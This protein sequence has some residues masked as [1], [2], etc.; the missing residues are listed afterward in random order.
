MG[1]CDRG[2]PLIGQLIPP[3][4]APTTTPGKS[5]SCIATSATSQTRSILID[6]ATS[7]T[8]LIRRL[9]GQL[10]PSLLRLARGSAAAAGVLVHGFLTA[11]KCPASD[12]PQDVPPTYTIERSWSDKA[13]GCMAR[14]RKLTNS[15]PYQA[16]MAMPVGGGGV[17]SSLSSPAISMAMRKNFMANGMS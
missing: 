14:V 15:T 8:L 7:M 13:L 2:R 11:R 6:L 1:N 12:L 5:E 4:Q 9:A 17:A 3:I 10:A 16:R